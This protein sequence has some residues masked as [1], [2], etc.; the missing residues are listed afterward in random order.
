MKIS[1]SSAD[2]SS[3]AAPASRISTMRWWMNSIEPTSSP[4]VGW[5]TMSSRGS[6]DSSRAMITF[7]WL[8]PDSVATGAWMLGVRTS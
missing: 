3:T 2:T 4:R 1:S 8:P 6:P 5:A 7:C